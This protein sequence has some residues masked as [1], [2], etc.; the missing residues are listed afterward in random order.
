MDI[1]V[2]YF[3]VG[4]AVHED[5]IFAGHFGDGIS[6]CAWCFVEEGEGVEEAR[7]GAGDV[8]CNFLKLGIGFFVRGEGDLGIDVGEA[9]SGVNVAIILM[10]TRLEVSLG[11]RFNGKEKGKEGGSQRTRGRSN[12]RMLYYQTQLVYQDFPTTYRKHH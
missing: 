9:G 5:V 1:Q 6:D 11:S 8:A 4:E 12:P 2:A 7:G 10:L 3:F